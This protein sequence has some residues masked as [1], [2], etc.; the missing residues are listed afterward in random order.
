MQGSACARVPWPWGASPTGS[1]E[2]AGYKPAR[3]ASRCV[4]QCFHVVHLYR[5]QGRAPLP[6][7]HK[8][9]LCCPAGEEAAESSTRHIVLGATKKNRGEEKQIFVE[10]RF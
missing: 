3:K 7:K 9:G 4:I 1:E 2:E 10:N 6:P 5:S 8:A